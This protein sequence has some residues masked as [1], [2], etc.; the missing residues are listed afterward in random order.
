MALPQN[1]NRIQTTHI[2]SLPRPH[3]VLDLLKA[4]LAG[5]LCLLKTPKGRESLENFGP[6]PYRRYH[7][8]FRSRFLAFVPCSQ[9]RL[10]GA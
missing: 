3:A 6:Q 2:G 10:T 9:P 1:T 8:S 7:N 4:K 5:Q